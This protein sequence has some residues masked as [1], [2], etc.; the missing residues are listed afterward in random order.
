MDG[1]TVS[2]PVWMET[3]GQQNTVLY[4]IDPIGSLSGMRINKILLQIV[5]K[6]LNA[7]ISI[8]PILIAREGDIHIDEHAAS[9]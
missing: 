2:I 7:T 8:H 6:P 3:G 9:E 4:T 5:R 1:K